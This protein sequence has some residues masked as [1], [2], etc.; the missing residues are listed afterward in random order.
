MARSNAHPIVTL[1][2]NAAVVPTVLG[3]G[4]ARIPT[5]GKIRAGIK[6]LTRRAAEQ[7]LA[8]EIYDEGVAAGQSFE[9]I[10]RTL[11]NALPD[12]KAPLV[13]R[14]VPWFTVR[15]QDFSN[16]AIARQIIDTCGE[17]RGEGRRVYRF[18]VVFPSDHW[19]TVMPH[20]LA[21]WGSHEKRYWSEYSAD[22]RVRHCKCHA[23]TSLDDSGKRAIRLFGGR[24]TMLREDNQGLCEPEACHEYQHRQCNLSGR[25]L[26]FIPGIR[27]ISA[28]ELHTNSFYAMNAAIQKF[29]TI[30]FLRGGRISGFLDRERTPFYL[31]KKLMDVA[32]IDD[33]GRPV[34]VR[35]WIIDLEAPVDVAALMRDGEDDEAA[36]EQAQLAS[37]VLGGPGATVAEV[38][39]HVPS[40]TKAAGQGTNAPVQAIR[41][42]EPSLDK[43]LAGAQAFGIEPG[44]YGRYAD[45]RWGPGWKLNPQGRRRAWD[46]LE[47]YRNDATGYCDKIETELH[48]LSQE[49]A[50]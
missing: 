29:E 42:G 35:Q 7:P 24:K 31:S 25:F 9:Q 14:N 26:F 5:G 41:G 48:L 45:L 47:R 22:G 11:A 17:D 18:P 19:Q 13:P 1:N 32:H 39:T 30:G 44:L 28:F 50:P 33:Q 21:A 8:R 23:P 4:P 49:V 6:V 37:Q 3:N 10:E 15:E 2:G 27:S 43:V 46:E 38:V 40:T 34:R 36:I 12:L 20:E 16:P